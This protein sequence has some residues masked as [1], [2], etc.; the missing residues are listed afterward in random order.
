MENKQPIYCIE[1]ERAVLSTLLSRSEAREHVSGVPAEW[2]YSPMHRDIF[3]LIVGGGSIDG[4]TVARELAGKYRASE[5]AEVIMT[6]ATLSSLPTHV[7]ALRQM[8]AK[9]I[10]LMRAKEIVAS[11]HNSDAATI[12]A[13]LA[14]AAR[15]INTVVDDDGG[16]AS[17]DRYLATLEARS[18][19]EHRGY[20]TGYNC[21]DV[22]ING[23]IPGGFYVIAGRAKMGKTMFAVNLADNLVK[24]GKRVMFVSLEMGN[25]E[26]YDLVF[27]RRMGINSKRLKMYSGAI[28]DDD[29]VRVVDVAG[30]MYDNQ[31]MITRKGRTLAEV[32]ALVVQHKPDVLF[33]D[34]LNLMRGET[35]YGNKVHEIGSITSGLKVLAGDYRIPVVLIAQLNRASDTREC[36]VP[37]PS[38]LRD[39]GSIEQDANVVFFVY[40]P[41]YYDR[42]LDQSVCQIIVALNRS[43][44][45]GAYTFRADL[46]I[47][48]FNHVEGSHATYQD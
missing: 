11:L 29:W 46:A 10:A 5:I 34:N 12:R 47:S 31:M 30:K 40:R 14:D 28:T 21:I 9:R 39:S 36:K 7:A 20:S 3:A 13:R 24:A 23:L 19:G 25:D 41:G 32:E 26:I 42:R 43:G 33:V 6:Q 38:D 18:R 48:S 35:K 16:V 22:A 17:L 15:E 27:A 45:S 8:Y 4:I 2:F 37:V 1:T 44:E